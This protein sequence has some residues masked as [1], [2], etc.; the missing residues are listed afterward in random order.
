M[1]ALADGR[2]LSWSD[3][4]TLR[5]TGRATR[6][7]AVLEGHSNMV[8]GVLG[9]GRW[10]NPFL[11]A[12]GSKTLRLWDAQSGHCLVVLEG[13]SKSVNGALALADGR[14]LSWS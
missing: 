3:D 14:V 5:L 12:S 2:I 1:L 7:S 8:H 9:A 11:A 13:H 6:P 4:Q 10:P